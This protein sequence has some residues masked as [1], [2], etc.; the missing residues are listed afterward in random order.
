MKIEDVQRLTPEPITVHWDTG[1]QVPV[2][3]RIEFHDGVFTVDHQ[4]PPKAEATLILRAVG[5]TLEELTGVIDHYK[6]TPR[7]LSTPAQQ[8]LG[9]EP[10]QGIEA[11][12]PTVGRLC[13]PGG[14]LR[15]TK[16]IEHV[17]AP[18]Y[19]T[20]AGLAYLA[21][22]NKRADMKDKLGV[23]PAA[24]RHHIG[25][26]A[27]QIGVPPGVGTS[28]VLLY[29]FGA[30]L[31]DPRTSVHE[32]PW[33]APSLPVD[34]NDPR[35]AWLVRNSDYARLSSAKNG[36]PVPSEIKNAPVIDAYQPPD[37]LN[38]QPDGEPRPFQPFA[39]EDK[40]I[41]FRYGDNQELALSKIE[42]CGAVFYVRQ[43]D[44]LVGEQGDKV[45]VDTHDKLALLLL[46]VGGT[47]E[48]SET[49]AVDPARLKRLTWELGVRG[50][51]LWA[52]KPE[53]VFT[54]LLDIVH[55]QLLLPV[56]APTERVHRDEAVPSWC[57]NNL[58]ELMDYAADTLNP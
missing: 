46:A 12:L 50:Q 38:N 39:D 36:P 24:I 15:L 27:E 51:S 44:T 48:D 22:G 53:Q 8:L 56:E 41:W 43:T 42:A 10:E 20:E 18:R 55:K 54:R 16:Q 7:R 3:E 32:Q 13:Y 25:T 35:Y 21:A 26:Y 49:Y 40:R 11:M 34:V 6:D 37:I 52:D 14:I 2:I 23:R 19:A 45:P 17:I 58:Y 33:P 9:I 57:R 47:L 31:L 29:A 1:P 28:P 30:G 4:L 5:L